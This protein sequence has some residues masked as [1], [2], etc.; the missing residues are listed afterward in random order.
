MV[1]DLEAI[2]TTV[3]SIRDAR[4][5]R[6]RLTALRRAIDVFREVDRTDMRQLGRELQARLPGP[7]L[8]TIEEASGV[9]LA[10]ASAR[11]LLDLARTLDR[12]QLAEVARVLRDPGTLRALASDVIDEHEPQVE[13][14]TPPPPP[15]PVEPDAPPPPSPPPPAPPPPPASRPSPG[16]APAPPTAST[17]WP[18]PPLRPFG[19]IDDPLPPPSGTT[20]PTPPLPSPRLAGDQPRPPAAS[21]PDGWRRRR[22]V[23]SALDEGGLAST[24]PTAIVELCSGRADRR[25]IASALVER[26]ML[27][28]DDLVELSPAIGSFYARLLARRLETASGE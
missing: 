28:E 6:E 2:A 13:V 25:W 12:E 24:V 16:P 27:T 22:A 4:N 17:G 9:R 14:A 20:A 1:A 26:G 8:A 19:G 15:E 11:E 21:R 7:L 18:L 10:E 3:E 5:R 23:I